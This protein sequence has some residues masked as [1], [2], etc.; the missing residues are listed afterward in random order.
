M[1][2]RGNGGFSMILADVDHFKH[3][4]DR[5]GHGIGDDVLSAVA[6][7]LEQVQGDNRHAARWGGEEFFIVLP[8]TPLM[9]A[10]RRAEELRSRIERMVTP[11][12][13]LRVTVSLGVAEIQPGKVLYEMGGVDEVS[14]KEAFRLAA[15]KLPL[16]TSF[17]VRQVGA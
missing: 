14:A 3:I 17:V 9:D 1:A 6:R 16:R 11:V 10:C 4:N 13:G 5:Y 15:S 8:G 7:E 2:S 12:R